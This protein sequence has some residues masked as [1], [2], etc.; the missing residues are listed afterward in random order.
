MTT[1]FP[2]IMTD[3][4]L[5]RLEEPKPAIRYAGNNMRKHINKYVFKKI[6]SHEMTKVKFF[7]FKYTHYIFLRIYILFLLLILGGHE[8]GIYPNMQ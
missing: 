1:L 6:E 5:F 8:L 3:L 2:A 4:Q 7:F